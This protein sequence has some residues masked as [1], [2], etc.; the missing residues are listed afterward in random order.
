MD[1][2]V[3]KKQLSLRIYYCFAVASK[4]YYSEFIICLSFIHSES[5]VINEYMKI[6]F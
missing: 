6:S 4:L 2:L 5:L 1:I 3:E